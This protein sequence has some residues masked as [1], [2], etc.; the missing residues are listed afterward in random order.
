MG[1]EYVEAN[2]STVLVFVGILGFVLSFLFTAHMSNYLSLY[3]EKKLN[4]SSD[5]FF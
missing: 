4:N 2:R 5:D 1:E 3:R